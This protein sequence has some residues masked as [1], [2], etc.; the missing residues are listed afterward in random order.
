M[1]NRLLILTLII[2]SVSMYPTISYGVI[3]FQENFNEGSLP[4]S[5]N[6]YKF[7]YS[8]NPIQTYHDST[9]GVNNS[10]SHRIPLGGAGRTNFD[11][12]F[13]KDVPNLSSYYLRFYLWVNPTFN[14]DPGANWKLTYNYTNGGGFVFWLRPM[15][16]AQGFQPAFFSSAHGSDLIKTANVPTFYLRDF[17]GKWVCFEYYINLNTRRVKLWITTPDGRYN[18]TLYI[19]GY[20]YNVGTGVESIKIGAYWDGT[21]DN[22]YFKIDEVVISDNYIGPVG[23]ITGQSEPLPPTGLRIMN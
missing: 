20:F 2:M 8:D 11:V 1:K 19:D 14:T 16:D 18:Q 4:Y 12:H 15:E 9:G 5:F 22:N 23:V 3:Y 17:K 13:G 21:G 7:G 10:G 6:Y